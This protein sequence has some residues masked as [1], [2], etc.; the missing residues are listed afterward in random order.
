AQRVPGRRRDSGGT[1]GRTEGAS[2]LP[3][4]AHTSALRSP[5]RTTRVS[6]R[7][8]RGNQ[9]RRSAWSAA[10]GGSEGARAPTTRARTPPPHPPPPP[11]PPAGPGGA[12]A[13]GGHGGGRPRRAIP[14][15][16]RPRGAV[17][18]ALLLRYGDRHPHPRPHRVF[19]RTREGH[20]IRAVVV[21]PGRT[22]GAA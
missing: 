17:G 8:R 13:A 9:E 7:C 22:A 3:Q 15:P 12:R 19:P 2:V 18:E 6:R 21:A 20:L 1:G 4:L 14:P 16:R 5:S 11:T 10:A